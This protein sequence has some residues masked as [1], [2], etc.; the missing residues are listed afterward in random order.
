M[1]RL[2]NH[3]LDL[4][5]VTA[6]QWR[7]RPNGVYCFNLHRVGNDDGS[8]FH[9]NLFSCTGAR[10]A[11]IVAFLTQEFEMIGLDRLLE[12]IDSGERPDRRYGMITFDD[13]Y[14]D[15]YAVA[16]PVLQRAGCPAG[17]FLPTD[18]VGGVDVPWWDRIAWRVQHLGDGRLRI[19]GSDE[20]V[21]VRRS[22]LAGSIQ[23]VLRVVKDTPAMP[24]S[25]KVAAIERQVSCPD[26]AQAGI[27]MT[28]EQARE[29]QDHGMWFG[30][31]TR[32]HRILAP[33]SEADQRLELA[34]SRR[35]L[36]AG[37]GRPV[38]VLAYPVGGPNS[39]TQ[40]TVRIAA[41][42]G[43]R[44]AFTFIAGINVAPASRRFELGRI[45]IDDNVDLRRLRRLVIT[46][47]AR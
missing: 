3:A 39:Y 31:H 42:C 16:Y 47:P 27:F 24:M 12:L 11:E 14:V 17:F 28:W 22:D 41:E 5:G 15:N 21:E 33:L 2:L 29:M 40:A 25:E 10:F 7:Q 13:G 19:P 8:A 32:S 20:P 45:S 23:R 1:R 46:A 4:A 34:E 38:E 9:P 6:L 30:S 35:L 18:F 36:E 44:A 37:L 43:Y 26:I